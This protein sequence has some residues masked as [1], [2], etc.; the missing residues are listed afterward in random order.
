MT[1]GVRAEVLIAQIDLQHLHR[2]GP[3]PRAHTPLYAWVLFFKLDGTSIVV[4][5]DG[6]RSG[7]AVLRT[8]AVTHGSLGDASSARRAPIPVSTGRYT[9]PLVEL[10]PSDPASQAVI[11][12]VIVLALAGEPE[13]AG[14]AAAEAAA[15]SAHRAFER[16]T[17]E[18][19]DRL[20]A[21]ADQPLAEAVCRSGTLRIPPVLPAGDRLVGLDLL[22]YTSADLLAAPRPIDLAFARGA[23]AGAGVWRITG[24]ARS[25]APAADDPRLAVALPDDLVP[26]AAAPPPARG[27]HSATG[28]RRRPR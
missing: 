12:G 25:L 18:A 23:G 9:T 1:Q 22:A 7:R 10:T 28:R 14:A 17:A 8:H 26:D 27:P 3:A 5:P 20:V 13:S 2:A 11:G 6:R 4:A 16:V 21:A 15:E 19:L 24:I